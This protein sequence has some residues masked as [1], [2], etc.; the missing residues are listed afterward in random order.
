MK[1]AILTDTHWG[2]RSDSTVYHDHFK[3]FY[4]EQFFPIVDDHG[5]DMIVHGGDLTHNRRNINQLTSSVLK[6]AF[7]DP[8]ME[9]GLHTR[10][11]AGNHDCY[12]KNTN[13]V[14]SLTNIIG[15]NPVIKI[16]V[17]KP[18]EFDNVLLVPW[19]SEENQECSIKTLKNSNAEIVIGHFDIQG[20]MMNSGFAS[21]HGFKPEFFG[22][23][24]MVLSGHYH[25]RSHDRNIRYLG[26]PYEM[27][28]SDYKRPR[29]F[30]ILDTESQ[31]LEFFQNPNTIHH[32]IYYNGS[33]ISEKDIKEIDL[34]EF[35]NKYVKVVVED[36]GADE[37][38][39]E[40]FLEK[41]SQAGAADIKVLE[42]SILEIADIHDEALDVEDT[43]A[44]IKR[45]VEESIEGEKCEPVLDLMVE[46]Y[47]E[48][49]ESA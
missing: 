32:K 12:Y 2:V 29:G 47:K 41:L 18:Y 34:D 35:K 16:H 37:F 21:T 42:N 15:E 25:E 9:R 1:I 27:D 3:K 48:A 44:I 45:K 6:E 5:V 38:L 8:I 13:E 26:A 28:W 19:I 31:E 43:L 22:K 30:S 39:Y 17:D 40:K 24:D 20:F 4:A 7:L 23:F 10:I 14:N 36:K 46:L 33:D 11:I 49:L